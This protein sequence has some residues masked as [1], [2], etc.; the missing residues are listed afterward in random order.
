MTD[1]ILYVDRDYEGFV[2]NSRKEIYLDDSCGCWVNK[3]TQELVSNVI[4]DHRLHPV[5][6][7]GYD[8]DTISVMFPDRAPPMKVYLTNKQFDFILSVKMAESL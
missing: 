2:L 8:K 3:I 4:Y 5:V 7:V 6:Y 1:Y